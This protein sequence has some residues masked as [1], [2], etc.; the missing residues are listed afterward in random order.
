LARLLY[1]LGIPEVGA[2]TALLLAHHAGSLDRLVQMPRDELEAIPTIGPRTA[3]AVVDF[4]SNE[5]NR[6][7]LAD[8]LAVG[9][10]I[11]VEPAAT[12]AP[13][14]ALAGKRFVFTGTLSTMTRDEAA[15]RV[16]SLGASVSGSVSRRTDYV[17]AGDDGGSKAD[18]ARSLGLHLV[19][20]SEFLD[21]LDRSPHA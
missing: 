11:E 21:L 20:E 8:L 7:T 9:L 3:G 5:E 6:R 16:Q 14:G 1:G 13:S 15:R 4:F 2:T 19:S 10:R 12:S 17:V 18:T